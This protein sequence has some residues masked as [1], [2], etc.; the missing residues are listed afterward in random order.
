MVTA[1]VTQF[2]ELFIKKRAMFKFIN[3]TNPLI[4]NI[5]FSR[6]F[7]SPKTYRRIIR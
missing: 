7:E 3:E 4:K 1:R 5:A 2:E 6:S